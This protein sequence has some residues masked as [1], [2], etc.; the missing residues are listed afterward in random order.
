M[1]TRFVIEVDG[2]SFV[3]AGTDN[4][5]ALTEDG[6]VYAFGFSTEY[7][8]GLGTDDDVDTPTLVANTAIKDHIITWAGCGGQFSV[9]A[10]PTNQPV[11]NGTT[12]GVNSSK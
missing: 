6:K 1:L 7:Q 5:F 3:T 8:T 11:T 4:S 10:G 2:V 9:L 12:N